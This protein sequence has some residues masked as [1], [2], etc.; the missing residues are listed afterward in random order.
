VTAPAGPDLA[1]YRRFPALRRIPRVHLCTFPSPVMSASAI[2]PRLW[3]KRDDLNADSFGGNKARSLEFLLG[4]VRAG[5]TVLTLGGAG[6]THVLATAIHARAI[7]ASTIAMR[8]RHDMNPGAEVVSEL[9]SRDATGSVSSNA[10]FAIVRA[11]AR[12]LRGRVH[13]VPLGGSTPLG[14]L[15]QVNAGLELA[16]QIAAGALPA[17]AR[18]V[19]PLGSGGTT[20]GLALGFAI[21]G[22]DV[23][24]IGARVAPRIA[25][26]K[27]RVAALVRG[28]RKLIFR[29]TGERVV[30]VPRGMVRVVHDVYGGAYGR[31]LPGADRAAGLLRDE[32]DIRLDSTYSAKAFVAALACVREQDGPTLFWLTFDGR[33]L[34]AV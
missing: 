27:R 15:A 24:V 5:D 32:Y 29:V 19:L 1:L 20:A 11:T 22:L 21:A 7:G 9:I 13:Y 12:R 34:E 33:C 10:V 30:P 14:V 28:A 4:K 3:L 31:P 17:P 2:H 8:W 23:E 16:E 26:N 6:S 18:V 25:A